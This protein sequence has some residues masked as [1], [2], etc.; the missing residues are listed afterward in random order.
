MSRTTC[1]HCN[2]RTASRILYRY[3]MMDTTQDVNLQDIIHEDPVCQR[4]AYIAVR[5]GDA[6]GS[7]RLR[8]AR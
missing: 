8:T 6:D 7:H 2:D 1:S 5:R 3:P 4:C